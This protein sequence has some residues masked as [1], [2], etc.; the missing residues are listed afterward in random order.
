MPST[1]ASTSQGAVLRRRFIRLEACIRGLPAGPLLV[2]GERRGALHVPAEA[3]R[4]YFNQCDLGRCDVGD[5]AFRLPQVV[6]GAHAMHQA[7][8]GLHQSEHLPAE[9]QRAD[10]L[11]RVERELLEELSIA[12]GVATYAPGP[13]TGARAARQER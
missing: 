5:L 8:L 2:Q 4:N 3:V 6:A 11:Q 1:P 9:A 7:V 10:H 12:L 13:R